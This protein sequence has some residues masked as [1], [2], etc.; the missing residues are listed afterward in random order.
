MNA[1]AQGVSNTSPLPRGVRRA[2]DAMRGNAGRDWSVTELAEA[3]GLSSRTLQRQFRT[4]LGQ[5]PR[6]TLRDVRFESARRELLQGLPDIKVM[7]VALRCGFPHFGRF[8]VGYRRRFGETPSQ[9]LKR[10]AVLAV[11]FRRC[12]RSCGPPRSADAVAR[13]RSTRTGTRRDRRALADDIAIALIAPAS[14]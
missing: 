7:D 11:R 13:G 2:L 8:S 5:T 6:A 4:F 3:A 9:T 1:C 12:R 10:Q 14:P